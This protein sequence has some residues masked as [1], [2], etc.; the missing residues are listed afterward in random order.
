M[1]KS[2]CVNRIKDKSGKIT[3]YVLRDLQ[4]NTVNISAEDLKNKI[5]GNEI[6]VS[7]LTLT[8]D[9]RLVTTSNSS[10]QKPKQQTNVAKQQTKVVKQEEK[11]S[12]NDTEK[13]YAWKKDYTV[14]DIQRK[15]VADL[16][17]FKER[18]KN[19]Q[20][21]Q[22]PILNGQIS[23]DNSKEDY[24]N[25]LALGMFLDLTISLFMLKDSCNIN[26]FQGKC[27]WCKK[28]F[29]RK[30]K[31]VE[32]IIYMYDTTLIHNDKEVSIGI[33]LFRHDKCIIEK[34]EYTLEIEMYYTYEERDLSDERRVPLVDNLDNKYTGKP[35]KHK[36]KIEVTVTAKDYFSDENEKAL[37]ELYN[38]FFKTV[39]ELGMKVKVMK[40]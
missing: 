32:F 30:D 9:N 12:S 36:N 26:L 34:L 6:T 35:I 5:R 16:S 39:E 22:Y 14:T 40:N 21:K 23:Y 29:K 7:N 3:G 28:D 15:P 17:D 31:L 20:K 33:K 18:K 24:D 13:L 38:K 2:E 19:K 25:A 8:K 10:K 1:V 11:V 27:I 4:G 37:L